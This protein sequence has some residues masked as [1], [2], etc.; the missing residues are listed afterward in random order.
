MY[1]PGCKSYLILVGAS[2][3]TILARNYIHL[4]PRDVPRA[5]TPC[6]CDNEAPNHARS[7]ARS[8]W[9]KS[10]REARGNFLASTKSQP[11]CCS[12]VYVGAER[13]SDG[14]GWLA[15]GGCRC[16]WLVGWLVCAGVRL[17][18]CLRVCVRV[19]VSWF[20]RACVLS[21][22]EIL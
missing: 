11:N 17:R 5:Q 12:L 7:A 15:V 21:W 8:A 22:V 3:K 6:S 14:G 19:F 4:G 2:T 16:G 20:V 10:S 1:E 13:V 18:V 9:T